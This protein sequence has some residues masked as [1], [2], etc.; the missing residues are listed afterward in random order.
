[1]NL[2]KKINIKGK[3]YKIIQIN[4]ISLNGEPAHGLVDYD[5]QIILI[6]KSASNESK[7]ST[8]I[9]ELCHAV[10]YEIGLK[11]TS[12]TQDLEEL[13]A[14]NVC[15]VIMSNFRLT[16]KKKPRKR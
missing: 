7:L 6:E 2:P 8:L 4:D 16:M 11:Q 13:L 12:L 10:W 5:K 14:E 3:E 15:Q 9:H 1:M